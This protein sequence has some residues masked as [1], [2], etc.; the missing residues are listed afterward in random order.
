MYS[1]PHC[2]GAEFQAMIRRLNDS[3]RDRLLNIGLWKMFIYYK[4]K[5]YIGVESFTRTDRFLERFS[6]NY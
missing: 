5:E 6:P 1:K 2:Q 3:V 4:W